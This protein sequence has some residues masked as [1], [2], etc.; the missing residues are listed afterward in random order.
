M[1]IPASTASSVIGEFSY[2]GKQPKKLEL[3]EKI[4][5]DF[6]KAFV[7]KPQT[8]ITDSKLS[9]SERESSEAEYSNLK[10][11]YN[12]YH[13]NFQASMKTNEFDNFYTQKE[14]DFWS[15]NLE[16]TLSNRNTV[17]ELSSNVSELS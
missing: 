6:F 17:Q 16:K 2:A 11:V 7:V 9:G 8:K 4:F 3:K 10:G 13:T 12:Q 14:S 5:N 1:K 15:K